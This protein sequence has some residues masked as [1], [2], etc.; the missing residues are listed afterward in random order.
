[1]RTLIGKAI[2]GVAIASMTVA[3][4]LAQAPAQPQWKDRAEYDLRVAIGEAITANNGAKALELTKT[5]AE[6][7]PTSDFK[8]EWPQLEL[9]AYRLMNDPKGMMSAAEKILAGT[10]DDLTSNYWVC[11]LTLANNLTSDAE[12]ARADKSGQFLANLQKPA[13]VK[14][15]DWPALQKE[16]TSLGH[17]CVGWVAMNRKENEKAESAFIASL[18]VKGTD[19]QINSLLGN[20]IL[21][22]KVPEK[23]SEALF[24][25]ARASSYTGEGAL[26]DQARG[27][28]DTFLV[29]A[30]NRFHGEDPAGLQELRTLA[31]SQPLPPV[32]FKILSSSEVA[33]AKDTRMK[34]EQP[35]RYFWLRLKDALVAESGVG[36]F[37]NGM[38]DALVPS[39]D[40]AP[41]KGTIVSGTKKSLTLALADDT[42]PEVTLV[43]DKALK[44]DPT[45][46]TVV[47][48]WGVAQK[49]NQNPFMLEFLIAGEQAELKMN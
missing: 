40:Q 6:K 11:T 16:M 38:K 31:K 32:G 4:L 26:P 33:I 12:L 27:Q 49:L 36:Y 15:P 30:Y 28:L 21:A 18:K 25:Y 46:G 17:K 14:D 37:E 20:V 29:N 8:A 42:T 43:L 35:Q 24:H 41:L 2:L 22:Q 34:E 10:P 9:N 5:W 19:A 45:P 39:K 47:E 48:F 13:A 3:G 44:E 7:Y 1:M 23:Q